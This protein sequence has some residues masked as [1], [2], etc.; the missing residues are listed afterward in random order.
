M[1]KIENSQMLKALFLPSLQ[2]YRG[3]VINIPMLS[4]GDP[5]HAAQAETLMQ[6]VFIGGCKA[7]IDTK[8][9]VFQIWVPEGFSSVTIQLWMHVYKYEMRV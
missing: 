1:P 3:L 2:G 4:A 6:H 5:E 7:A 8:N 9:K